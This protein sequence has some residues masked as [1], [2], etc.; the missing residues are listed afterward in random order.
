MLQ[1]QN[2]TA[3]LYTTLKGKSRRQQKARFLQIS[4]ATLLNRDPRNDPQPMSVIKI[5][6]VG[7]LSYY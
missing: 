2:L 4:V 5:K 1:V 7:S 6:L 3:M